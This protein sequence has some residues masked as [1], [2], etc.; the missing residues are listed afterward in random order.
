M[1]TL[2][3]L[4]EKRR[5]YVEAARE[6]GFE[7]GLRK[8]L[9][10]LYPD[11]AHFIYELLQNAEDAG[12][13][14][15]MF[16]L[17]P[18]GLRFE[19]DGKR[20]FDLRD[21]ES[22]TGIG[23]S[24][25]SDD[26]TKIGKFGV[27]FKAVFAYTQSPHIQSGE[28]SFTIRDLFVPTP[29]KR[30]EQIDGMTTFWFPFDRPD[31]LQS[32]AYAEVD[33][34]LCEISRSTLLF[35][36]NIRLILCTFP[37]R[38]ERLLERRTA[39]GG[40]VEIDSVH[41]STEP[42]YW[43]RV[44]GTAKVGGDTYPVA[45]A[46]ALARAT[47][48]NGSAT[49]AAPLESVD[50]YEV[51]PVEGQV[52]IYFPAVRETSSLKFHI[53]APFAS[54]VA[55]DSVRDD[56]GNDVLI[57][58]IADVVCESLPKM[59]DAGLVSDGLLAVLPN[60]MD[61]LPG[62]Y[63]L[64]RERII[65]TFASKSLAPVQGGGYAE[66]RKLIRSESPLRAALAPADIDFFRQ[67]CEAGD[68]DAAA[69]WLPDRDGR[70][71]AFLTS[72]KSI[73]FGSE[74]LG[75]LFQHLAAVADDVNDWGEAA[76]DYV[77]ASELESHRSWL[78]WLADCPDEKLRGFYAALGR[79]TQQGRRNPFLQTDYRHYMYADDFTE[80]LASIAIVRVRAGDD[81]A[82]VRGREA[83]LPTTDGLRG[84]GLVLD[85]LVAFDAPEGDS[86]SRAARA[87]AG[88]LRQFYEVSGVRPWDISAQLDARLRDYANLTPTLSGSHVADLAT[89][90]HLITENTVSE[91]VYARRA[92][93]L[94]EGP[95]GLRWASASEVY[96]DEP[97]ESTGLRALYESADFSGT[98]MFPLA[99]IYLESDVDVARLATRLGALVELEIEQI[100]IWD[101]PL[102]D[103]GWRWSSRENQN[104]VSRDWDLPHFDAIVK[105]NDEILLRM[106]WTLVTQA[107]GTTALAVYRANASSQV[108]RVDS[109]LV[110]SL[111]SKPWILDRDGNLRLPHDATE[112]D[113]AEGLVLP[114][115][116]PLLL[117]ANFGQAASQAAAARRGDEERAARLGFDSAEQA[118]EVARVIAEDPEAFEAW[119]SSRAGPELPEASS[120]APERRAQRVREQAADAPARQH[121]MRQRSVR[122]Q[123][124]GY[125]STSK[126]YLTALYTNDDGIMVCQICDRELPFKLDDA[127]YFEAVQFV[128]DAQRD[129][130]ENRLAL[131]PICAAKYRHARTTPLEEV[132]DDLLT[133]GV[134]DSGSVPVEVTLAGER[135]RIRFVG[136]HAIDLQ[137]AL[138]GSEAQSFDAEFDPAPDGRDEDE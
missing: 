78:Q 138:E 26:T 132:R 33:R 28:H 137:A 71:G 76:E 15:V 85:S 60:N 84:D 118:R 49:T 24:T 31:K 107:E 126:S 55:R 88:A 59:R 27:G 5:A 70:P 121:E 52:F 14:E 87:E 54:T 116:A 38:E 108:H 131:C 19:H 115:N 124:P 129:L 90:A 136:R 6:N 65:S 67:L 79:L 122:I 117:A 83:F 50:H 34:A 20:P 35:L 4:T 57:A 37:D 23:Q 45:A 22:I 91:R 74:E 130:H 96:L 100:R 119:L 62:R 2:D 128:A 127:Y 98:K 36:N 61:E 8:L 134:G 72:L 9:A 58:G 68:I 80:S 113:L 112:A 21:I 51:R 64:F 105:T 40:I 81:V 16:E 12:A 94:A 63:E 42:S 109:R 73:G 7:E 41:E 43:Y 135:Q 69:G 120:S 3:V 106:L 47:G 95:S 101:N 48:S 39:A 53:H 102:F 123:E 103:R 114:S 30:F 66:S 110:Q 46:F 77:D 86:E 29:I 92:I 25:K 89:L 97:F 104:L 17:R 56:E 1:N 125:R 133:Q 44:T 93:F 11:N 10:D 13:E 82:H 32:Q 99:S 18:D 111:R 75:E